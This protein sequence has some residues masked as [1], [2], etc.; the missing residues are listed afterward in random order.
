MSV[1]RKGHA[2][3]PT[4]DGCGAEL[5]PEDTFADVLDAK[6]LAGWRSVKLEDE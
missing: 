4:C 5:M 3:I 1:E 6:R 2:Y